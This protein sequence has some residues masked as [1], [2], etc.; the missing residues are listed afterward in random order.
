MKPNFIIAVTGQSNSQGNGGHY[1]ISRTEDQPHERVMGWNARDNK[2]VIATLTDESLGTSDHR[3]PGSQSFAFH[4][5][6]QIAKND[7]TK[8]VG[9]VN[10]G[11]GGQP[12]KRWTKIPS[13]GLFRLVPNGWKKD[14]TVF[15]LKACND[16]I[17]CLDPLKQYHASRP[18]NI[19][20][21][22]EAFSIL[23]ANT[24][25]PIPIHELRQGKVLIKSAFHNTFVSIGS[26]GIVSPS[27][28]ETD[29]CIVD[30]EIVNTGY[31]KM[32]AFKGKN[33]YLCLNS[34]VHVDGPMIGVDINATSLVGISPEE[35]QTDTPHGDIYNVH[36]DRIKKALYEANLRKIDCICWHQGEAD[37]ACFGTYYENAIC[38]T[39]EQY[40]SESFCNDDTMFIVGNTSKVPD[41]NVDW[42]RERNTQLSKLNVDYMLN[43]ACVDTVGVDY[44]II[45][46]IHFS[47]EGHRQLGNLYC[48][49]YLKMK[50]LIL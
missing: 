2:W 40:R 5:A 8:V 50:K 34:L 33:G 43:T 6:K 19:N 7:P 49:K 47:S 28:V 4:F 46:K 1:E 26:N 15:S 21:G 37:F 41:S 44:N 32:Y 45:D 17:L 30:T 16:R 10:Y 48:E 12:I 29:E 20:Y 22:W 23:D 36:V 14:T 35:E 25:K 13:Q 39:I 11:I 3:I 31:T 38:Q 42:W 24:K 18:V 9:I 27:S